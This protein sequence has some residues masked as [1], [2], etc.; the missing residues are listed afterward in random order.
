VKPQT[1]RVL[2]RLVQGCLPVRLGLMLRTR[3]TYV[4]NFHLHATSLACSY[5]ALGS[6]E[7][8]VNEDM[9]PKFETTI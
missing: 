9:V 1:T 8:A 7:T 3:V 6:L 4:I 2:E 5:T